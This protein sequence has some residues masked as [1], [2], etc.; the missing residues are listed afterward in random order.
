LERDRE[1]PRFERDVPA[2]NYFFLSFPFLERKEKE[3][4]EVPGP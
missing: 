2:L 1:E 4:E 3:K